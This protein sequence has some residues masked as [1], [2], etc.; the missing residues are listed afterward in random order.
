MT[1]CQ[2]RKNERIA[3]FLPSLEGGGAERVFV[4]L[5]NQFVAG[6]RSVDLV[7]AQAAGP[8]LP[9]V[10]TR[11]RI[12]DLA[13]TRKAKLVPALV[14]YLRRDPP[15]ILVSAMDIYNIAALFA[16]RLAGASVPVV[17]T[18]HIPISGHVSLGGRLR[19]RLLPRIARMTYPS[20][21]RIIA[22]SQG[23]ADD[24]AQSSR[25]PRQ[26]VDIIY[27]PVVTPDLYDRAREP[28]DQPWFASGAPPVLVSA[29]RLTPQKD[30]PTLLRAFARLR[31]PA[32]LIILG[33]GSERPALEALTRKLGIADVV[34]MP[35]FVD[36]PFA[37]F[38][39]ARLFVLSSGWE[40]FGLVL[41]EALACGCPVISTDC[42]SGPSEI[43]EDRLGTLVPVG[44]VKAMTTAIEEAL[45]ADVNREPLKARA[46]DF[47]VAPIARRYLEVLDRCMEGAPETSTVNVP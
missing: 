8:Y 1:A 27:N 22:V 6:G 2:Q 25:I 13:A 46:A 42:P 26:A 38:A 12:V 10:D 18:C 15:A 31:R 37:Y 33:E 23:V 21:A 39:R 11:V 4:N 47:A 40:G 14:R 19:D 30:Y 41:V 35:G 36:N 28:L 44:D 24:L 7:L 43:L 9:F 3:L 32:R 29:G 16:R 34:D 45:E 20:A 5:A 17:V